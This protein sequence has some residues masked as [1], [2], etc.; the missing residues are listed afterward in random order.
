MKC[1]IKELFEN[2]LGNILAIVHFT[3]LA[4]VQSGIAM[5]LG[6]ARLNDVMFDLSLP[7]RLVSGTLAGIIFNGLPELRL[8]FRPN[9]IGLLVFIYLQWLFI[10]WLAK[11]IAARI[12]PNAS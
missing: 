8:N 1:W 5:Q 6:F 3:L 9:S 2:R 7:A 4:I 10:G 11:Y 12:Q